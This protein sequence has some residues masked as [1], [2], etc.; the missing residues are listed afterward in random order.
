MKDMRKP[1]AMQLPGGM[2]EENKKKKKKG[3]QLDLS[4]LSSPFRRGDLERIEVEDM[5]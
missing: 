5:A 4:F 1:G 3:Q 2:R